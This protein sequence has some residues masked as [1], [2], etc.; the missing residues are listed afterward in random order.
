MC[1]FTALKHT[2]HFDFSPFKSLPLD[3]LS[4]YYAVHYVTMQ[5]LVHT[6][7][8]NPALCCC[9]FHLPISLSICDPMCGP[10]LSHCHHACLIVSVWLCKQGKGKVSGEVVCVFWMLQ[11]AHE[12]RAAALHNTNIMK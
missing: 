12:K 3:L 11:Y 4:F 10:Q 9:L 5:Q 7:S 1:K 6:G 2:L 8:S